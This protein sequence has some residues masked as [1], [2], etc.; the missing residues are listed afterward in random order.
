[1][2]LIINVFVVFLVSFDAFSV[3][4]TRSIPIDL[5]R[6]IQEKS[7]VLKSARRFGIDTYELAAKID[8]RS[9]PDRNVLGAL[10]WKGGLKDKPTQ[11]L[12][13]R[14]PLSTTVVSCQNG[15]FQLSQY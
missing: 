13:Y 10:V 9:L 14:F 5:G 7:I 4:K 1:M 2:R 11:C 15:V 3:P 12:G 8:G 6:V